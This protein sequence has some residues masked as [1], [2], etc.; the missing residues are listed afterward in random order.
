MVW[1]SLK[2]EIETRW[3]TVQLYSNCHGYQIQPGSKWLGGLSKVEI[4]GLEKL[5]GFPFPLAYKAMLTSTRGIDK[6]QISIDPCEEEEDCYERRFYIYPEDRDVAQYYLDQI[7][8]FED[9]VHSALKGFN[10]GDIIGYIPIYA[11]RAVVVFKD[12]ALS[13]VVSVMGDD[14]VVY[15]EDLEAYFRNEFLPKHEY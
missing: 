12:P 3:E 6:E 1:E 11:H 8:E 5:M 2:K 14:V 7:V 9:T 10:I 13:P 15:G 4:D